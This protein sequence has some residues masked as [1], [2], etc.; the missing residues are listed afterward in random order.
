MGLLET[1]Q[2]KKA[3]THVEWIISCFG[4]SY[5]GKIRVP[6]ECCMG[7]WGD[8]LWFPQGCQTFGVV[9]GHPR[10]S[11]VTAGMNRVSSRAEAEP[12]GSSPFSDIDLRVSAEFQQGR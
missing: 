11:P 1:L 2:H 3:S 6:L 7:T 4:R 12:Q 9:R 8:P 10:D 5:E